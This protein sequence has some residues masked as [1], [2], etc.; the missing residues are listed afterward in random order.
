MAA[1][2]STDPAVPVR[3]KPPLECFGIKQ[4]AAPDL[5]HASIKAVLDPIETKPAQGRLT[6]SRITLGRLTK[7][8]GFQGVDI[9]GTSL[10]LTVPTVSL[11]ELSESSCAQSRHALNWQAGLCLES[12]R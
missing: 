9:G 12:H 10:R 3:F 4:H 1:F 6:K 2:S 8:Q 11:R 5:D 7:C